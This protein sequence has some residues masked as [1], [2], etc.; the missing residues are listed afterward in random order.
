MRSFG[1]LLGAAVM[2]ALCVTYGAVAS[3]GEGVLEENL[4]AEIAA[5]PP[6]L[7]TAVAV[8]LPGEGE[9]IGE[10]GAAK[11]LGEAQ[12]RELSERLRGVAELAS[13]SVL[14]NGGGSAI[15]QTTGE[16]TL[17]SPIVP[18]LAVSS[19]YFRLV[20]WMPVEGRPFTAEEEQAGA[21]VCLVAAGRPEA[22]GS[23]HTEWLGPE[24]EADY[25]VVGRLPPIKGD[26]YPVPRHLGDMFWRP[27][28]PRFLPTPVYMGNR[29]VITPTTARIP[30]TRETELYRSL[31]PLVAPEPGQSEAARAIVT[32]YMREVWPGAG[33]DLG[34]SGWMVTALEQASLRVKSYGAAAFVLML[35]SCLVGTAGFMGLAIARRRRATAIERSLGRSRLII[36][37][38]A[39]GVGAGLALLGA[40]AGTLVGGLLLGESLLGAL[41]GETLRLLLIRLA[42]IAGSAVGAGFLAGGLAAFW[43][44]ASA[45]I[46]GLRQATVVRRRWAID[47]RLPLAV[48][49]IGLGAAVLVHV[50]VASRSALAGLSAYLRGVGERII[51]VEQDIFKADGPLARDDLLNPEKAA[52]LRENLPGWTVLTVCVTS[53]TA[54]RSDGATFPATAF[55]VD[56]PWPG[57]A[58][59]R[60]S[61]GRELSFDDG[62]DGPPVYLGCR[63][64]ERLFG[65]QDPVG[66]RLVLGGGRLQ[67][68]VA[69]VLQ[70]RPEGVPDRLGDR[71]ESLFV[72]T[73]ALRRM[74][75]LIP[76][77][78][79]TEVWVH[80]PPGLDKERGLA[81]VAGVV[82]RL[83]DPGLG[84]GAEALVDQVSN[85]SRLEADM[86]RQQAFLGA[87]ALGATA[88]L[89]GFIMLAR[90]AD[91][92]RELGLRRAVGA[93]PWRIGLSTVSEGLLICLT[94]GA[95][96]SALGLY[97]ADQYCL[98]RN[99]P[100]V[101]TVRTPLEVGGLLLALGLLASLPSLRQALGYQPIRLLRE[102][103]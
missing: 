57:E 91:R 81:E 61:D 3:R 42:L 49:A 84:I 60:L 90:L 4:E 51:L 100:I 26:P 70:P 38:E 7:F 102:V 47:V 83:W 79:T 92:Q 2:S 30:Y 40:V 25:E 46:E 23:R 98:V 53:S 19:N 44:T 41:A 75:D 58:G 77:S 15:L 97:L 64:A 13:V 17:L 43:A 95:L 93:P 80:L 74:E 6:E 5:L 39:S 14:E 37:L 87:M 12:L 65:D 9:H 10:R 103:E 66:E 1:L 68:V 62:P 45:P 18:Y 67:A 85:L 76:P 99:W 33:I 56:R 8:V 94:G 24:G 69:G 32:E 82:D 28:D 55:G 20:G 34:L 31:L 78:T 36:I 48:L 88:W 101:S 21:K 27:E 73:Q 11:G 89:A 59:Y 63:L 96:G 86:G 71:D 54:E 22:V 16:Y 35:A 50:L 72:S 52:L 29:L